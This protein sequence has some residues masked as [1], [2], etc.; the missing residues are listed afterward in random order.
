MINIYLKAHNDLFVLLLSLPDPLPPLYMEPF[1]ISISAHMLAQWVA[2]K[3]YRVMQF[4]QGQMKIQV[5]IQS[6]T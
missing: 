5:G 6:V 1:N 2:L 4:L 3:D